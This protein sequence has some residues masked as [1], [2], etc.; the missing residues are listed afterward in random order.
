MSED[1]EYIL[2]TDREELDR[3]RFQHEVWVEQ[4]FALWG[5]AGLREGDTVLDLGC[6]PGFTSLDLAQVVGQQGKVLAV[7]KSPRF[8]EYLRAECARLGYRHV[9]PSLGSVEEL[10]LPADRLDAAYA[11]WLLCWL[12][13]PGAVL[14]R[15]A[16][17]LKRGGVIALQDY[18]DWG[19]MKLIPPSEIFGRVVE[20][21][22]RSWELGGGTIDVGE[23][24]PAL[25]AQ[26]GLRVESFRPLAR[27]GQVGSLEWRWLGQ[28]FRSYL[29]RLAERGLL[30]PDEH[31]AYRKDWDRRTEEGHSYCYTPVMVDVILTRS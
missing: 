3:L 25:A 4:A 28:F 26:L 11:R 23:R 19:A 21:C 14:E 31:D 13:D 29:P 24:L 9:E 20:A 22:M 18:L 6:G 15:T 27:I 16:R 1:G 30:A 7:D 17:A 10:S 5:R 8:V 2:G 12:P